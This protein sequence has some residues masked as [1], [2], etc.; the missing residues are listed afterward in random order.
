MLLG[1]V[2]GAIFL[3]GVILFLLFYCVGCILLS[4]SVG[5]ITI[6]IIRL[7]LRIIFIIDSSPD[8]FLDQSIHCV[9]CENSETR[10]QLLGRHFDDTRFVQPTVQ[11]LTSEKPEQEAFGIFT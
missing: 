9:V 8:C 6:F 7:K 3:H 10:T 2:T 11:I 5:F 4:R 1:T